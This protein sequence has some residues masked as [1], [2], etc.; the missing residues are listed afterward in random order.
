MALPCNTINMKRCSRIPRLITALLVATTSLCLSPQALAKKARSA[1]TRIESTGP[2]YAKNADAQAWAQEMASKHDLP[3]GWLKNTL[4]QAKR[5]ASVIRLMSPAPTGFQK[6]WQAYRERFI[7]PKRITAGI[8]FWDTHARLLEQTSQRYGVAPEMIVGI[9]GVETFYGRDTGKFRVL[10]ALATLAFDFPDK[11]PRA[12]QRQAYFRQELE[13]FVLQSRAASTPPRDALGSHA[14][15][16]GWPQFMPGS[17]ARFAVDGDGDGRIDLN[18]SMPDILASVANYFQV[19]GWQTGMPTHHSVRFAEGQTP[20]QMTEL[21]TPDILPSFSSL[22]LQELGVLPDASWTQ[23][24]GKLALIELKNGDASP[25]YV[26][27]TE[28]FY[29][30]T[31]YNWSAYY[32]MA[33]IELGRAVATARATR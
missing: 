27:G 14:G 5:N 30:I 13:Q 24:S 21:L 26:L 31:R 29:V 12:A 7:E 6:N 8:A 4:A 33:V 19:H 32:A 10:D 22:R 16:M 3:L 11:H 15:A 9:L 23:S 17:V 18:Q 2:S 28:N 25:S 1:H 20:A